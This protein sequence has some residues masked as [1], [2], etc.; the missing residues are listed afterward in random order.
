MGGTYKIEAW[1]ARG[2]NAAQT[3]LGA[4]GAFMSSEFSLTT[5][6]NLKILVGQKGADGEISVGSILEVEAVVQVSFI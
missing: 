6:D 2:G 3:W 5:E 1:G 4:N